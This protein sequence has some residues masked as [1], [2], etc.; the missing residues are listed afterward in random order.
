[1]NT[2]MRNT[3]NKIDVFTVSQI[4]VCKQSVFCKYHFIK[5]FQ[6]VLIYFPRIM[7]DILLPI[8]IKYMAKI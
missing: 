5:A 2:M 4:N 1:M 3:R 7:I 6:S 8:F